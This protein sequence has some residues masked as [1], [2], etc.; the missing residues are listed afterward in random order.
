MEEVKIALKIIVGLSYLMYG[1]CN[2]TNHQGGE[3]VMQ[4][5]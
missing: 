4:K 2:T 3:A 1:F 5:R